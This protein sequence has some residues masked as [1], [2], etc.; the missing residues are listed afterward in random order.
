MVVSAIETGMVT[1]LIVNGLTTLVSYGIQK[2]GKIIKYK[3]NIRKAL[4]D[5]TDLVSNIQG[6]LANIGKT[7]PFSSNESLTSRVKSFL[8]SPAMESI[9]RQIY[10]D[11]IVEGRRQKSIGQLQEEFQICFAY[12]LGVNVQDVKKIATDLFQVIS[13]GCHKAFDIAISQGILSAHEAKS[14]A[15][16]RVLLDELYAINSNLDFLKRHAPLDLEAISDFEKRYRQQV[17]HRQRE[18]T[19][20][21]FERAPRV[22][23]D[24][25]FVPMNF[26]CPSDRREEEPEIIC[27]EDFLTRLYRSVL[28]G[29]PGGG[30]ST[31]AQKVCHDLCKNYEGRP[32]SGRLLTPVLVILREYSSKKKRDGSSIIQFIESEVTSKYQLPQEAPSGSFEYL[33]NNGHLLII[34]DG[35]D[36]LLDPSYRREV[37]RDIELFCKLFPSVPALI[38]SRVVGYEQAPLNPNNF[39]TFHLAPFN[40]EQVSEYVGKWFNNDPNLTPDERKGRAEAFLQE[41]RIVSDLR[42]NPLMLAL[43][44]NLYR[45]A[46]FIPR[47]RPEVYKKCSE[48]LFERWDPS[49]GIYWGQLPISEPK[50]LLSHLAHWIYSDESLQSGITEDTLVKEASQF[51]YPRR[52]EAE[53]EAEKA[54][55]EFI[56]FCRGRAWVFT[57]A[58]MTPKGISLYK[59][60]HKTFLEYFTAAYLV[61]NNNVPAEFW[62][63]LGSKIAQRAWDVV[64]QL[65]FQMLHEQVE[66]ASDEVLTLLLQ[67]AQRETKARWQYLSFGARCLQFISFLPKTIRN[68]TEASLRCV[69]EG[70]YPI[71]RNRHTHRPSYRGYRDPEELI[72][73]LILAAPECRPTVADSLEN[74]IGRVA[75]HGDE[76]QALRAID[77]GLTLRFP[78]HWIGREGFPESELYNYWFAVEK[79]IFER[80]DARLEAFAPH[81][82]LA[83]LHWFERHNRPFEKLLEWYTPDHLFQEQ[84]HLIY[85][86]VHRVAL[87]D[88]VLFYSTQLGVPVDQEMVKRIENTSKGAAVISKLLLQR[89]MPCF[90]HE[91]VST[92]T[93]ALHK[94]AKSWPTRKPRSKETALVKVPIS[95]EAVIGFWCLWAAVAEVTEKREELVSQLGETKNP[96]TKLISDAIEARML[97]TTPEKVLQSLVKFNPPLNALE[98]V[99]RWI[100]GQLSFVAPPKLG[101][102]AEEES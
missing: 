22:E 2:V 46:G 6:G 29:D 33:L 47:N 83:F 93:F 56:D 79:R 32:V 74:E 102:E 77:L 61:R 57:D 17:E 59:F 75:V 96:V 50:V 3:G 76:E 94:L 85:T 60:T 9:V 54:S 90:S 28:L 8:N 25:I 58:G 91:A 31:L 12:H 100:S 37:S 19:I 18:I 86:S 99:R 26:T 89:E 41:S 38:T 84:Q 36:E 13:A 14:I 34:F 95:G 67:D 16:H 30:K 80:V 53:E 15:R 49:R 48:M 23:I 62:H 44:C 4:E 69:I 65:A 35:L 78:L 39:E 10:S 55:K 72:G 92:P 21:H 70:P 98:F 73:A 45:G 11:Y 68:L 63:L 42:S 20:P 1:G 66:G 71:G 101:E 7:E 5:D 27:L 81:N 24:Q 87:A 97:R 88:S 52:F 40:N 51:L 82:F 64:A 43:M